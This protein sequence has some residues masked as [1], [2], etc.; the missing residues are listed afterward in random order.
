MFCKPLVT[1]EKDLQF[2]VWALLGLMQLGTGFHTEPYGK[3]I[4]SLQDN[5]SSSCL[6]VGKWV[7]KGRSTYLFIYFKH[8]VGYY[9]F[10][11]KLS[12]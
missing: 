6:L 5:L 9:I 8:P 4:A 10:K 11:F 2:S 1:L 3:M 12:Y 7:V